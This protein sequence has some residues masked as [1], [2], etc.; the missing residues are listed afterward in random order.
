MAEYTE[1]IK[2]L[3]CVGECHEGCPYRT[4][5][6]NC[7]AHSAR[8]EQDAA[9]AIEAL[10]AEVDTLKRVDY[11]RCQECLYLGQPV[12]EQFI[13][14]H[15]EWRTELFDGDKNYQCSN[16]LTH[17]DVETRYCPYCGAKM[18]VQDGEEN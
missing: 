13:P 6:G 9:A 1:L 10:Q 2:A 18:E 8:L 7:S 16:C 5:N 15:G 11:K 14:K 3:R 17:W 4:S 12:G